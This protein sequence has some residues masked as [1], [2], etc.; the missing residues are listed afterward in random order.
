M[1][2]CV[3]VE[4]LLSLSLSPSLAGTL[5]LRYDL[6]GL[7]EPFVVDVDQRN[8][9]NGQPHTVNISRVERSIQVQVHNR[10]HAAP[11]IL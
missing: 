11:L 1:Y 5:Q 3:F 8:L 2:S 9:A 10:R 6:G 7:K 4:F